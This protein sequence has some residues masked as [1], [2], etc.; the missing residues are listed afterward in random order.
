[1]DDLISRKDT[2]S[3][4]MGEHPEAHY[5]DWYARIIEELPSARPKSD[6]NTGDLVERKAAIDA[7]DC[8]NGAEEVLKAL[9][10]AKPEQKTGMWFIRKWG[11]DAKCSNCGYRFNDV[12]DT[13]HHMSYFPCDI[14]FMSPEELEANGIKVFKNENKANLNEEPD[15]SGDLISRKEVLEEIAQLGREKFN[16]SDE[17]GFFLEGMQACDRIIRNMPPALPK[18][19]E[20]R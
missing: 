12:Y 10:P 15:T 1:M 6:R 18:G 3:A 2:I 8:I 17:F 14:P 19:R 9:P 4:I 16:L 5:P 20:N 13:E 11:G 7:L